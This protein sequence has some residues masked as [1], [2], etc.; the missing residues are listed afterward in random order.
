M[1]KASDRA[2]VTR[3]LGGRADYNPDVWDDTLG[4]ALAR[5]KDGY[6][7]PYT[8]VRLIVK[9]LK[10]SVRAMN[11]IEPTLGYRIAEIERRERV[12]H[13]NEEEVW[14]DLSRLKREQKKMA[15]FQSETGKLEEVN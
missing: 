15:D 3:A 6:H 2:A 12:L 9:A 1:S 13:G 8:Q 7:V 11:L 5:V 4:E 14:K 10:D